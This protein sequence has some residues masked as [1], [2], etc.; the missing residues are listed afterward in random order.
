MPRPGDGR[1]LLDGQVDLRHS[2]PPQELS[3]VP[4][5]T[6][7][8]APGRGRIGATPDS[9][10]DRQLVRPQLAGQ[11]LVD[12][13][14][15]WRVRAVVIRE[16][17]A[18]CEARA[19]GLE[20]ARRHNVEPRVRLVAWRVRSSLHP[21][22]DANGATD[23]RWCA[24]GRRRDDVRKM[25]QAIHE[26]EKRSLHALGRRVASG[27]EGHPCRDEAV[28]GEAEIDVVQLARA[29]NE[30]PRAGDERERQCNLRDHEHVT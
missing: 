10:P 8:F 20:V 9:L 28:R 29:L 16:E 15:E 19:C 4:D 7:D 3:H 18:R 11:R 30:E 5:Y 24:V 6:N 14:N 13:G 2:L 17:S 21:H 12:D 23:K 1:R 22:V 26:L 27:R 25:S